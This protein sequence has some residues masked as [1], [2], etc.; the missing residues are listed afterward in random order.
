MAKV[1]KPYSSFFG[2]VSLVSLSCSFL[3]L[4]IS[5]LASSTS[6]HTLL[7]ILQT[8]WFPFTVTH[9][10]CQSYFIVLTVHT[11][12]VWNVHKTW[13]ACQLY[14]IILTVHIRNIRMKLSQTISQCRAR[15]GLPKIGCIAYLVID[16]TLT[17]QLFFNSTVDSCWFV[18]RWTITECYHQLLIHY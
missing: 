7:A 18:T 15:S 2:S 10:V 4:S 8:I 14:F 5:S 17:I 9:A 13:R 12:E 1:Y 11:Q 16:N 6:L 3:H